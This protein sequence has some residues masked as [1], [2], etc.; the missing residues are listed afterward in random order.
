MS[1]VYARRGR[2]WG[3]EDEALLQYAVESVRELQK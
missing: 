2:I 3:D 1:Q